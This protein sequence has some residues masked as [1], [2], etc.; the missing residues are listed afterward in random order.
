M[1]GFD[2]GPGIFLIACN[3]RFSDSL[4]S[5]KEILKY[6]G[7]FVCGDNNQIGLKARFVFEDGQAVTEIVADKQFE[8][9]KGIYHGGIISTVL[10][11]V[12]IKA[13]LAEDKFAVSA[14]IT[15]RF[16]LPINVGDK[17]KVIGR[18]K[19]VKGR[20]YYTEATAIRNA[21]EIVASAT[22]K[23]IEAKPELIARLR[24]SIT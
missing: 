13:I 10:D 19:E 5:M 22:G 24:Q 11:E 17:L 23:C 21:N 14:E 3:N 18:V 15:V 2:F 8:G 6:P 9:Y 16:H 7:C 4:Y 12:M 20:V 1:T